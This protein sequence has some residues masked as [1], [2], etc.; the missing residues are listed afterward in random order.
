M[1]GWPVGRYPPKTLITTDEVPPEESI[2]R[3]FELRVRRCPGR[4]RVACARLPVER[5]C[6]SGTTI[7]GGKTGSGGLSAL[8]ALRVRHAP[9]LPHAR[10]ARALASCTGVEGGA[11]RSNEAEKQGTHCVTTH[12][13]EPCRPNQLL[14]AA[15]VGK[16]TSRTTSWRTTTTSG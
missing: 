15:T 12:D 1:G 8:R 4:F 3:S 9:P 16:P 10:F 5:P 2:P 14:I 6:A 11:Q 7:S 13:G